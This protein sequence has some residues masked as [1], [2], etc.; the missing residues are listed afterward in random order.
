MGVVRLDTRQLLKVL[1]CHQLMPSNVVACV[2]HEKA[3]VLH[4]FATT[5]YVMYE[6]PHTEAS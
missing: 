3:L 2:F 1:A 4:V 5:L 6:V